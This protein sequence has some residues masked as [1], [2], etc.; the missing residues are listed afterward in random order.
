MKIM[1]FL[2]VRLAL[3]ALIAFKALDD[4]FATALTMAYRMNFLGMAERLGRLTPGDNYSRLI[5]LMD[6]VP[7][8]LHGLWVSAGILYLVSIWLVIRGAGKAYL[9]VLGAV[10]FEVAARFLG[11]PV[12]EASGVIVNPNPSL[13]ASVVIPY[14]LP[15]LIALVLWRFTPSSIS[16]AA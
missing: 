11:K 16:T 7:L 15:L 3:A 6:A 9:P 8:W 2:I 4:V 5:P 14:I 1:D 13:I 12:I 10:L